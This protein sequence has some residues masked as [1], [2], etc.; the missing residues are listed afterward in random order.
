MR[1]VRKRGSSAHAGDVTVV[2]FSVEQRPAHPRGRRPTNN[3]VLRRIRP[4]V[5]HF[6]DDED[7]RAEALGAEVFVSAVHVFNADLAAIGQASAKSARRCEPPGQ[8][9]NDYEP[10]PP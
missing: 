4:G 6:G 7:V 9:R 8:M 1:K 3:H 10:R 5:A 2:G